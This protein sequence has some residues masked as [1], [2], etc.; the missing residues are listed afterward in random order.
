MAPHAITVGRMKEETVTEA[1]V[2][3]VEAVVTWAADG[4]GMTAGVQEAATTPAWVSD[5]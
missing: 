1:V 3:V 5:Y 4:T 2:V